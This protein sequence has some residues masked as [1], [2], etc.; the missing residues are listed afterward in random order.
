[1]H[2]HWLP[3]ALVRQSYQIEMLLNWCKE[4]QCLRSRILCRLPSPPQLIQ[5]S[6]VFLWIRELAT[7]RARV[8]KREGHIQMTAQTQFSSAL[9][10]L[11]VQPVCLDASSLSGHARTHGAMGSCSI[12]ATRSK[13][14]GW[15]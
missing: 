1:M 8:K 15:W 6:K 13:W 11:R 2:M 5:H 12:A 3:V 4:Q 14:C 10:A 7:H 9:P